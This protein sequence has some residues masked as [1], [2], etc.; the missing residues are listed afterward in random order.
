MVIRD[1]GWSWREDLDRVDLPECVELTDI[2]DLT[3][4]AEVGR[5][6]AEVGRGGRRR[7]GRRGPAEV[8]RDPARLPT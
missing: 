2:A 3:E 6:M 4:M 7:G 5:E 1:P 8:G